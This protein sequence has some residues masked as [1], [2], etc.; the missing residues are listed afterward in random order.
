MTKYEKFKRIGPFHT[1]IAVV[2]ALVL[3]M[4]LVFLFPR[5]DIVQK[6]ERFSRLKV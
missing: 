2:I 6:P 5:F 3:I 4:V 1:E